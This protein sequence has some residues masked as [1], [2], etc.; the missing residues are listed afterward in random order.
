[1]P[2]CGNQFLTFCIKSSNLWSACKSLN[3]VVKRI[4]YSD[5]HK[6]RYVD[7]GGL[8]AELVRRTDLCSSVGRLHTCRGEGANQKESRHDTTYSKLIQTQSPTKHQLGPSQ[9]MQKQ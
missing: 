6:F 4:I 5:M 1:M 8:N 3:H 7:G 2:A 9:E